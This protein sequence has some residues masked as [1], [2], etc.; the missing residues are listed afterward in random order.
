ML[1]RIQLQVT[2]LMLG[3][4]V[5]NEFDQEMRARLLQFMTGTS[6]VPSRG[7]SVVQ[8]RHSNIKLITLNGVHEDYSITTNSNTQILLIIL[9]S[10]Q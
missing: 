7:F 2:E 8:G 1:E 3:L 5:S 4:V 10:Q 6:G 9:L